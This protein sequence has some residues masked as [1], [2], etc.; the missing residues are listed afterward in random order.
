MQHR[1]ARLDAP[2]R[3]KALEAGWWQQ[4]NGAFVALHRM[5]DDHLVNAL[6]KEMADAE[7]LTQVVRRLGG[8]VMRRGLWERAEAI[9]AAREERSHR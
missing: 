9:A 4:H 6:L 2:T 5:P 1:D 3:A 8:E 7:T